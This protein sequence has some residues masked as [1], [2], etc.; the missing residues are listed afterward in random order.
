[1]KQLYR[2]FC[3]KNRKWNLLFFFLLSL[4]FSA[5][6]TFGQQQTMKKMEQ[7]RFLQTDKF[8]FFN[9]KL[10]LKFDVVKEQSTLSELSGILF[11]ITSSNKSEYLFLFDWQQENSVVNVYVSHNNIVNKYHFPSVSDSLTKSTTVE[12]NINFKSGNSTLQIGESIA[13]LHNL[14][15]SIQ[16]GYKFELLPN[17]AFSKADNFIPIIGVS[18]LEIYVSESGKSGSGWIWFLAIIVADIII[19]LFYR[20]RRQRRRDKADKE[21]ILQKQR[22]VV[23]VDLPVKSAIYIFGRFHVYDKTGK[24]ITKSLSPLLRELL[25]LLIIYSARKG[26]SSD[27]LKE[28]LWMDKSDASAANNRSVYFVRLRNILDQLGNF[29]IDNETGYWRLKTSDIFIDYYK[30]KELSQKETISKEEIDVLLE[31]LKNGNLLPTSNYAWLDVF[32]DQTSNEVIKALLNFANHININEQPQ[33]VLFVAEVIFKFDFLSEQALYL[34]IKAH[35]V[36]GQH[37][38]AKNTYDKYAQEYKSVYD[39]SFNV[40]FSNIDELK[41]SIKETADTLH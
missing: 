3:V 25:C 17:L 10:Q 37:A 12:L 21:L 29:E 41:P 16:N 2:I 39:E 26:I 4:C 13:N 19:F 20:L 32:K 38:L 7:N 22:P 8:L 34:K 31:I 18:E 6:Q 1:M 27:K 23:D 30:Y 35:N 33:L 5:Q 36:L 15:F 9:E 28:I 24:D 11:R 40:D 14:N